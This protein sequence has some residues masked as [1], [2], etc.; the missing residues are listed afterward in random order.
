[1]FLYKVTSPSTG[2]HNTV[3]YS[4][5]QI[6]VNGAFEYIV[7]CTQNFSKM[8]CFCKNVFY[9]IYLFFVYI[10]YITVQSQNKGTMLKTVKNKTLNIIYP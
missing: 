3:F 4:F 8:Q 1:M 5:S 10:F 2:M 6:H 7:V 9:L